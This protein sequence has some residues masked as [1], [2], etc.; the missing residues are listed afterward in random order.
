MAHVSIDDELCVGTADCARIAPTAFEVDELR[1]LS[2]PLPRAGETDVTLLLKAARNC[3][4]QAIRVVDD[5]G[6]VL[7]ASA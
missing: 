6:T 1:N 5:D 7:H 4:T 2:V 3:P